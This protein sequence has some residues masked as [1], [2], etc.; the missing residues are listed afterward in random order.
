MLAASDLVQVKTLELQQ[1]LL[2]S[3]PVKA[4]NTAMVKARAPGELRALSV[5]EGDTVRVGW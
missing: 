2:I 5:R 1:N 4:V 3:G